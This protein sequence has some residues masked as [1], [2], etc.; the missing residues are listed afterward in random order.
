VEAIPLAG[1]ILLIT[2]LSF[3]ITVSVY[4]LI[5]QRQ[6]NKEYEA[7]DGDTFDFFIREISLLEAYEQLD[8]AT[9]S[10]LKNVHGKAV[11]VRAVK[12]AKELICQ[13]AETSKAVIKKL[14]RMGY[15]VAIVG[16]FEY[17]T[18]IEF[19]ISNAVI[20]LNGYY[21]PQEHAEAT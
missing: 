10:V 9:P 1:V 17:K 15:D 14:R 7:L 8:P 6:A 20:A 21:V 12:L 19:I 5:Q 2:T 13:N 3:W 18:P 16:S 4:R 11:R